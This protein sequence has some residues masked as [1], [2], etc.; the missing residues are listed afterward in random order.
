M[1]SPWTYPALAGSRRVVVLLVAAL[2]AITSFLVS[3]FNAPA[4]SAATYDGDD[5]IHIN[6]TQDTISQGDSSGFT[7]TIK[8]ENTSG[9][10]FSKYRLSGLP[11]DWV[12][13]VDGSTISPTS[14]DPDIYEIDKSTTT[15]TVVA[16]ADYSG[17]LT[18]IKLTRDSVAKNLVTDFDNGT[19]DYIGTSHPQLVTQEADELTS[20]GTP[21]VYHDP[22]TPVS[23]CGS[24][25]YAPC[26][27]QYSIWP[28]ADINGPEFGEGGIKGW[29]YPRAYN[30]YWAD[31]RSTT[32]A[33]TDPT[34]E[35][36]TENWDTRAANTLAENTYSVPSDKAAAAG[37][38]LIVNGSRVLPQPH[39]VIT[40]TITGLEPNTDYTMT[41]Y[42]AN[43]SSQPYADV[44]EVQVGFVANGQFIGT[45]QPSP[46]QNGALNG[47][48]VWT[49]ITSVVNTGDKTSL[50]ISVRNY[51]A[52]G[53]GNDFAIDQLA[54]YPQATAEFSLK[55]PEPG[56]EFVKSSD[57]V[58]GSQVL[59][60]QVITYTLTGSNTGDTDLA[61]V[62]DDDLSDVFAHAEIVDGS[63]SAKVGDAD[64]AAPV[65]DGSSLTWEGNVPAGQTVTVTYQVKVNSDAWGVEF[66]NHATSEA[67]PPGEDVPPITPPPGETT[68]NTPTVPVTPPPGE[69]THNTPTA[70]VTP[71]PIPTA[72]EESDTPKL[73]H[74]GAD[75]LIALG[76]LSAGL[77]IASGL[78][79]FAN[80]RRNV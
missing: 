63:L 68:H 58:S 46:K 8:D 61:T 65:L 22:Q 27:G 57:P 24:G 77:L 7:V 39:D 35:V 59:P 49:P 40:T 5:G 30:N 2:L 23:S 45:S 20:G 19:F 79:W 62:I 32:N 3:G 73:A 37:K 67:T 42:T 52:G 56:Y 29:N 26:D 9:V 54:L 11:A 50:T 53:W 6:V 51:A 31:L 48:T 44:A 25:Q 70:P 14:P 38:F 64:V 12:V 80:K 4:A 36:V 33:M 41:G 71:T 43:V 13:K 72:Q 55:V 1:H 47:D 78:I 74:S 60:N 21:Y 75:D 28:T 15:F 17:E 34:T 66:K 18:G 10:N 69:T 16:P 76:L